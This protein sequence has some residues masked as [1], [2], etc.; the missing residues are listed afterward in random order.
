MLDFD[1]CLISN[2]QSSLTPDHV[3]Q[4]VDAADVPKPL[5][6][7]YEYQHLRLNAKHDS[8]IREWQQLIFRCRWYT[9]N[10][11]GTG[12]TALWWLN[13]RLVG[14]CGAARPLMMPL[15]TGRRRSE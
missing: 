6:G 13:T 3:M 7:L 14:S 10:D 12:G 9:S 1:C 11:N 2:E 5:T 8:T 15:R 4:R